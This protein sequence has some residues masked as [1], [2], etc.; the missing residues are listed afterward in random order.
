MTA[1]KR[2]S[3]PYRVGV[4]LTMM[5]ML[6]GFFG[7]PIPSPAPPSYVVPGVYGTVIGELQTAG[8]GRRYY[9]VE[10]VENGVTKQRV[11]YEGSRDYEIID[12]FMRELQK[13]GYPAGGRS[14]IPGA[15]GTLPVPAVQ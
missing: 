3:W 1:W 7:C 5:V 10:W 6:Q 4:L 15:S 2:W 11:V 9:G 8:D 14:S 13:P 12:A